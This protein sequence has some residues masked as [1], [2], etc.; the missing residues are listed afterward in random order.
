MNEGQLYALL[1]L[2][3]AGGI[4]RRG[5][6]TL[7]GLARCTPEAAA[8][9]VRDAADRRHVW[10]FGRHW[11]ADVL[12]LE[13][14]LVAH[15]PDERAVF[16]ELVAS[17]ARGHEQQLLMHERVRRAARNV[18]EHAQRVLLRSAPP[19]EHQGTRLADLLQDGT[20]S[21]ACLADLQ[22]SIGPRGRP[23]RLELLHSRYPGEPERRIP[24]KLTLRELT[25]LYQSGA[26]LTGRLRYSESG[27]RRALREEATDA[28]GIT[29]DLFRALVV[30]SPSTS[31][32]AKG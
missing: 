3:L 28:D 27:R 29:G 30:Q 5:R 23:G 15:T 14:F 13:A 31:P 16:L 24:R 7:G 6:A 19:P 2:L 9:R 11:T 12:A 32:A 20:S 10:R 17:L 8:R 22:V 25:A 1:G 18:E 4:Y 21:M 26:M